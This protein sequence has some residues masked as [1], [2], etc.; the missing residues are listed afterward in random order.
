MSF[1]RTREPETQRGKCFYSAREI[2][3]RRAAFRMVA[4]R[5]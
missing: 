2:P 5:T 4:S 1:P 3:V